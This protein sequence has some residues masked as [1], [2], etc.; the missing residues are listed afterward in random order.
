MQALERSF[1]L[2][3]EGMKAASE[4]ESETANLDKRMRQLKGEMR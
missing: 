2:T 3:L 1:N 4:I